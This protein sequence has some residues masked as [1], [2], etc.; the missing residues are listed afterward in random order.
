MADLLSTG[1]SGLL[2]SQIGLSTV[3]HNVANVNTDGYSR[4]TVQFSA[5]PAQQLGNFYVGTG[6][7]TVAVQRAYSQY[8]NTALWTASSDQSRAATYQSLTAQINNQLSGSTNLQTSL[9]AFYGALGDVS[10][11]P[12][13]AAARGVLLARANALGST[14]QALSGQ[15]NQLNGQVQRQIGDTV[16][17]INSDS[18]SIAKLNEQIRT[19]YASGKGEPSDLLDQR[20]ALIKKVSGEVGVTVVQQ[21]DHTVS[22]FVGNGQSL[23]NGSNAYQLATAPNQYDPTRLEIVGK[24]SGSVI[25]GQVGGGS[26][27]ALLDFRTNVLDPAQNQLGRAAVAMASAFNAQHA[28]GMD[29]NG[30]LGG[31][32]FNVG[33]PQVLNSASNQGT[34]TLSANISGVGALTAKDYV[35][36]Y[37]GSAWSLRDTAG[38]AVA[39]TGTGTAADPFKA[40]GLSLVVGGAP[41]AG[42]SFQVRPTAAAAAGFGAAITDPN[43]I[44][45]A[46]PLAGSA[47]AANKGSGSIGGIAVTDPSNAGLL[48]TANIVFTSPT[49]YTINGGAAQT[50]TPGQPINANG[51][52]LTLNGTPAANDTFTLKANTNARG[53]NGN[54]LALGKVANL[55]VLD[56]GATSVGRAYGQLTSQV[57]S[58]G[59]L[60]KD[61]L[62]TQNAVYQQALQSQQGV[63]GVNIDEEAA[64]LVRYQQAYQA[65]AQVISTASQIFDALLSAVRN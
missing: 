33:A 44:A 58:A 9:D 29:L 62:T 17:S 5:R 43:K 19:A 7:N 57:G 16:D 15:F 54:A 4:Q 42:D 30:N 24:D 27:G 38:N 21:D 31:A 18:T 47:G 13:D 8:L 51:W 48:G 63:S 34:G 65:S 53:D 22:L 2:A 41:S 23:V 49:S 61:A 28:Q 59:S 37:D 6:V 46:A 10:N 50:Y 52:S 11:A 25:T 26:L 40:D 55:G 14:F 56:N 64:S 32:F 45:A 60:A 35:L 1:V 12:A 36:R 20:D 3:S 39:M